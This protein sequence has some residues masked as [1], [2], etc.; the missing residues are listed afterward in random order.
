[1]KEPEKNDDA[2]LDELLAALPKAPKVS[3]NFTARV[4]QQVRLEDSAATRKRE[5]FAWLR[6]P[7]LAPIAGVT[8]LAA[9]LG[10]AIF[11]HERKE[12]REQMVETLEA[13]AEVAKKANPAANEAEAVVTVLSDFDAIRQL[14]RAESA[15]DTTLLTALTE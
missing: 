7:R 11:Q 8:S 4:L 9:I 2:A 1:M 6:F 5:P 10:L 15:I 14:S 13:V 12:Q 3:T